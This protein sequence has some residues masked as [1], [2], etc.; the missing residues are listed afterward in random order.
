M[1]P[2][3]LNSS[4]GRP[5]GTAQDDRHVEFAGDG[6]GLFEQQ[7]FYRLALEG[8]AQDALRLVG[9]LG[10]GGDH[11]DAARLAPPPGADLRLEHDWQGR[12]GRQTGHLL[13]VVSH[14]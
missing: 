8:Q 3:V 9:A 2:R 10:R 7:R 4:R 6:H 1:P 14:P 13:G 11:L 12:G 5:I